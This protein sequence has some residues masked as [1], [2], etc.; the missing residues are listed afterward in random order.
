MSWDYPIGKGLKDIIDQ[1]GLYPVTCLTTLSRGEKSRLLERG[2]VLCK[3]LAAH[4]S[5]LEESGIAAPRKNLAM[6]EVENLCQESIEPALLE[7]VPEV[8]SIKPSV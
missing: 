5:Y 4:P 3:T 2:I 1:A 8:I 6:A 7:N